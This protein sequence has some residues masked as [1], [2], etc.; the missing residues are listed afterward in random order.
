MKRRN[1]EDEF[2]KSCTDFIVYCFLRAPLDDEIM[3]PFLMEEFT[4]LS[5]A[6]DEHS[7]EIIPLVRPMIEEEMREGVYLSR[8]K[9][10]YTDKLGEFFDKYF[11]ERGPFYRMILEVIEQI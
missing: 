5:E 3:S 6:I 10:V 2:M 8:G 7:E 4:G 11:L 1:A 9:D